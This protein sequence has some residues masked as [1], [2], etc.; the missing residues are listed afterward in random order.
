[1]TFNRELAEAL[2]FDDRDVAPFF[3]GRHA[4]IESFQNALAAAREKPQAV[5]RIY[6][7]AARLR[8]PITLRLSLRKIPQRTRYL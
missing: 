5:F 2:K 1:M 7:D 4:E 6:Q 8:S 3:A